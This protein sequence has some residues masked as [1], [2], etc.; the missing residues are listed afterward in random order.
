MRNK[1]IKDFKD[2]QGGTT[3]RKLIPVSDKVKLEE[4][5]IPFKTNTLRKWHHLGTNANIFVKASGVLCIDTQLFW[6]WIDSI[7]AKKV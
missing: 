4:N 2:N 3:L 7:I 1:L 6:E 5:G